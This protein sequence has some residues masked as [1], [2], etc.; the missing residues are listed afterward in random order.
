MREPPRMFP[1]VAGT[2]LQMKLLQVRSGKSAAVLFTDFQN[3]SGAPALMN[4]PI[5]M[6]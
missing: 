2:R 4:S 5:G 1:A 6:K 3:E